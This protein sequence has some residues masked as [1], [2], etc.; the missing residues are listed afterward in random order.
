VVFFRLP[1]A[2][3]QAGFR[4]CLRCRPGEAEISEPHL[5]L[6]RQVCLYIEGNID[7]QVTLSALGDE[8]GL[9]PYHLQRLFKRVM[10]ITPRQY[11]DA[12]RL[13]RFK[14]RL[15]EG[16]NVTNAIYDAGYGSSS[17]LYER[18]PAQLG[19]TPTTYKRGGE[20]IQIG[21]TIVDSPLGRLLVAATDRGICAV[22]LGDDDE[23]LMGGLRAEYPAAEIC[24]E[25]GGLREWVDALLEYMGGQRPNLDLPID[26]QATAFQWRVW[27][28]LRAIP[29]G[30]TRSYGQV[31]A[32]LGQPNATRAVARACATNRVALVIPCHRVI[33]AGGGLG[34]YRWGVNRKRALLENERDA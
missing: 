7:G 22:S 20:Q 5:E 15:K 10:G 16:D 1:E 24:P 34:G 12:C 25:E 28:A 14:G 8:V 17:R 29:Y 30:T 31:A 33:A 19:M 9:S 4:P 18:A 26:V 32:D 6:I 3:E 23:A 2:A 11:A 13:D 27:E 21:Y